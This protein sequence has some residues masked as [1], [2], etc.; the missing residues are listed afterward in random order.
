MIKNI[1]K[2]TKEIIKGWLGEEVPEIKP[3]TVKPTESQERLNRILT[4]IKMQV[5]DIKLINF[6]GELYLPSVYN[7]YLSSDEFDRVLKS[8]EE[9]IEVASKPIAKKKKVKPEAKDLTPKSKSDTKTKKVKSEKQKLEESLKKAILQKVKD[10]ANG[11]RLTTR[12]F[13]ITICKDGTLSS[14]EIVVKFFNNPEE[15]KQHALKVGEL[16][17]NQNETLEIPEGTTRS[18]AIDFT[19]LYYLEIWENE[20]KIE[21]FP[22]SN[23]Q[24]TIGREAKETTANIKLK[25]NNSNIG[26]LHAAIKFKSKTDITV[27]A[28]HENITK[29][30][31][32]VISNKKPDFPTETKLNKNDEIQIF[33]F[34]IK[35]RF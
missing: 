35:L 18:D 12:K 15:A 30:G 20:N 26:R 19:T 33:G 2:N 13:I 24:V 16:S 14:N 5:F 27:E 3:V 4:S 22:I 7:V 23:K 11:A 8:E 21:E 29:V 34:K 25:T 1:W 31:K 32:T 17:R 28:M 10:I 6:D 9:D